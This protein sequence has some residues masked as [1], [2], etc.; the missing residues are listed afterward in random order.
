MAAAAGSVPPH[1]RQLPSLYVGQE[2]LAARV[3]LPNELTLQVASWLSR[4]DAHNLFLATGHISK[5]DHEAGRDFYLMQLAGKLHRSCPGLIH[6]LAEALEQPERLPRVLDQ[7]YQRELIQ[8]VRVAFPRENAV[9][10][11]L[12]GRAVEEQAR[13]LRRNNENPCK[14][15]NEHQLMRD[16]RAMHALVSSGFAD[17]PSRSEKFH[18]LRIA[19]SFRPKPP[20]GFLVQPTV[21][22]GLLRHP[23]FMAITPERL[24]EIIMGAL[25]EEYPGVMICPFMEHHSFNAMNPE[26]LANILKIAVA[27]GFVGVI[28]ASITHH[29]FNAMNPEQLSSI[30]YSFVLDGHTAVRDA[31]GAH[32]SFNAMNPDQLSSILGGAALRGHLAVVIGDFNTHPSFN[33]MNPDQLS[34]ILGGAAT[35]GFVEVIKA[36][37]AH[38]SFNAMDPAQL[39]GI[40][41]D[42]AGHGHL[43]VVIGDFNTHP[44]FNAMNPAQLACI[45]RSLASHEPAA[46]RDAF[47]THPSF[48]AMGP[49]QLA[50]ILMVANAHGS[51]EVIK[52]SLITH[53]SFNAMNPDQLSRILARAALHGHLAVVI[54]DFK[55]HP[56]F[57]AM[58]P[59]QLSRILAWPMRHGN[60]AIIDAFSAHPSFKEARRI[61]RQ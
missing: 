53:P 42:A 61:L 12:R 52:A 29:S 51:V 43:A 24:F 17:W 3:T 33:A 26:Q 16:A 32:P 7:F 15:L 56:S 10:L 46:M 2:G 60:G 38:P 28:K 59:D 30:I 5:E 48:N 41:G 9:D 36:L 20:G 40:L 23:D 54:G 55:T 47:G 18:L 37:I 4:E 57:N 39:T 6:G 8:A 11:V 21:L 13:L 50:D 45:I 44:S 34:R 49:A 58:N 27:G 19:F 25:R 35:H 14:M 1:S 31:F 22:R